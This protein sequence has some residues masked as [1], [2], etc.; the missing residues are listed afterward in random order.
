MEGDD[1]Q[2]CLRHR[3]WE[4]YR[5][6]LILPQY[7]CGRGALDVAAGPP[8]T[9]FL[10]AQVYSSGVGI[11]DFT[12]RTAIPWDSEHFDT[13]AFHDSGANTKLTIP[14][15]LNG[16]YVVVLATAFVTSTTGAAD[17]IIAKSGSITF[18]GTSAFK[19]EPLGADGVANACLLQCRTQPIQV[20][21]GDYFEAMLRVETDT[22]V[23][24]LADQS[25]FGIYVVGSSVM[26]CIAKNSADLTAQNFNNTI[27]TWNSEVYD[28]DTFHN[29]G[30]NTSRITIPSA[31]NGRYGILKANVRLSSVAA[32]NNL[33][34][35]I[36]R[37]GA[38]F[39]ENGHQLGRSGATGLGYAYVEVES[40]PVL[41]ATGD[42]FE[43]VC[44]C[45]DTSTTLDANASTF[46]I[47]I[48]PA[49]FKGVLAHINADL[50]LQNYST[51]SDL[52]FNGTDIYDT[53]ALHDPA[54]NNTK[55]IV[56]AGLNGKYALLQASV[57]TTLVSSGSANSV[58]IQKGNTNSY[59]GFGGRGGS[60]GTFNISSLSGRSQ[61][62]QLATGDEFT[63]QFYMSDT[64]ITLE[65]E[66]TT[67][68][69]RVLPE[70]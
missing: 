67:F 62:V 53:D 69:L 32:T 49:S 27:M 59:L 28:T 9:G 37:T 13:N 33:A 8:T 34:L 43:I 18:D 10:G 6:M 63:S 1:R 60:N 51:P 16:Y 14:A 70:Q 44:F 29:T 54:S 45:S 46:S 21:T 22:N 3:H 24:I 47:E 11:G 68:G 2:Q 55:I 52:I 30:A 58:V 64:S 20:S 31:A 5:L 36:L 39:L 41:L 66:R 48:M 35:A 26:G 65:Q 57:D 4:F 42:Y 61:I 7:R 25:S 38:V 40:Q 56:P 23:T 19:T 12:T 50:T 15:E 17:L